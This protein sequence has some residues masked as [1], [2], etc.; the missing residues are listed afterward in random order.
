MTR[1]AQRTL[2]QQPSIANWGQ[3]APAGIGVVDGYGVLTGTP[4]VS[5]AYADGGF[6]W[7]RVD[8]TSTSTLVVSVSGLFD[9]LFMSGGGGANIA[10]GGG[11]GGGS[12][13][14]P[15]T[16]TVYLAAATY[17]ITIGAG[18]SGGDGG[19]SAFS[20]IRLTSPKGQA[21]GT[22]QGVASGVN[23]NGAGSG[24]RTGFP[25]AGAG[26]TSDNSALGFNGGTA[27]FGGVCGGGAGAGGNGANGSAGGAGGAGVTSTFTGSSVEYCKGGS[28]QAG[29][30]TPAAGPAN[31]G[32]GGGAALA[33]GS[34]FCSVRFKV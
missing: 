6:N 26:A 17:T 15:F 24:Y 25:P 28:G 13:A 27:V 19:N 2:I 12:G 3:A 5:S 30:P 22:N 1:Y 23:A 7:K 16:G 34:G 8:F 18:G 10:N 9:V 14:L 20:S 21:G 32:T 33:G 29:T 11:I 31:T 4:S